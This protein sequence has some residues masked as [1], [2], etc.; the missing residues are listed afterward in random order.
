MPTPRDL[1]EIACLGCCTP[2]RGTLGFAYRMC[3]VSLLL[4]R[5]S[6]PDQS[7]ALAPPGT[8]EMPVT[9]SAALATETLGLQ[10]NAV[11]ASL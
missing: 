11:L 9:G 5:F 3:I 1:F 7:A 10:P 8:L 2:P 6:L 4:G